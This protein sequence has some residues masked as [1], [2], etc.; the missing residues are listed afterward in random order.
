MESSQPVNYASRPLCPARSP[1]SPSCLH[2]RSVCCRYHVFTRASPGLDDRLLLYFA[3]ALHLFSHRSTF[4]AL[5][6]AH[7]AHDH[8]AYCNYI[9]NALSRQHQRGSA[10]DLHYDYDWQ[11]QQAASAPVTA[12]LSIMRQ[13]GDDANRM[14]RVLLAELL[15]H[16][17]CPSAASESER[18]RAFL[19]Q[20]V[21]MM[22]AVALSL[23]ELH[24]QDRQTKLTLSSLQQHAAALQALSEDESLSVEQQETRLLEGCR[25]RLN[26]EKRAIAEARQRLQQLQQEI[27]ALRPTA[28]KAVGKDDS[29]D[30]DSEGELPADQPAAAAGAEK[31][32]A[33]REG[34]KGEDG[35]EAAAAAEA[36]RADLSADSGVAGMELTLAVHDSFS[37]WASARAARRSRP[38][39]DRCCCLCCMLCRSGCKLTVLHA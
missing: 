19:Q 29:S 26:D 37:Q 4:T 33:K 31:Q 2:P 21:E 9:L 14:V 18:Q 15:L 34:K 23:R 12:R 17:G 38:A 8:A 30:S 7:L 1:P 32:Q 22:A 25:Q 5:R 27:Q 24:E 36:D 20:E 3:S 16:S 10:G 6:P 11:L 35:A 39:A 28:K 13:F